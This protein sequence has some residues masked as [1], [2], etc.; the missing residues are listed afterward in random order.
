MTR[1]LSNI[2]SWCS[3]DYGRKAVL[4]FFI[5]INSLVC[6]STFLST[7]ETCRYF[8]ATISMDATCHY[9]PRYLH[10]LQPHLCYSI[11]L[12]VSSVYTMILLGTL[13]KRLRPVQA[14]WR[15][16]SN[17]SCINEGLILTILSAINT[18]S[19]ALIASLP[20]PI[21]FQLKMDQ[22]TRLN[23][24]SLLSLGYLVALVGA[25]RTYFVWQLFDT[26]DLTWWAA[27]HWIASEVE[28]SIAIVS[29]YY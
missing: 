11:R 21:L 7:D 20:I 29:S 24:L 8:S 9:I 13:T 2:C 15:W 4:D 19:E 5:Y 23:V 10:I 14:Y 12:R 26:N 17:G 1:L 22:R 28:I 6:P 18:F 3:S 27:P 16:P 25:V